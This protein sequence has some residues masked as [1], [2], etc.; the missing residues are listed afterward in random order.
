[1]TKTG[2]L[3]NNEMLDFSIPGFQRMAG[4]GPPKVG[5]KLQNY[6]SEDAFHLRELTGQTGHL[7]ELALQRLQINTL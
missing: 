1:M 2:I 5:I 4:A 7:E 3:L 6:F